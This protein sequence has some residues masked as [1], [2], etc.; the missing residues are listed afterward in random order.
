MAADPCKSDH[1][2]LCLADA[3]GNPVHVG[4]FTHDSEDEIFLMVRNASGAWHNLI[5]FGQGFYVGSDD[6]W[7]P[8]SKADRNLIIA[9]LATVKRL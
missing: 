8:T 5:D 9:I 3:T 6:D 7:T 1:N 4:L 2:I